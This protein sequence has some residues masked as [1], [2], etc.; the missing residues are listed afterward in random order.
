MSFAKNE[1]TLAEFPEIPTDTRRGNIP[2]YR[3]FST[4]KSCI[5]L[6]IG[7]TSICE[8]LPLPS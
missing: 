8:Y 6:T 4:I 7:K 3:G 1:V 5:A 2:T